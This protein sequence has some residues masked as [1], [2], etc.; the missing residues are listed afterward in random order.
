MAGDSFDAGR[1]SLEMRFRRRA[2]AIPKA[3]Y[4]T[5]AL[6]RKYVAFAWRYCNPCLMPDAAEVLQAFYMTLRRTHSAGDTTPI[7]TR[8]LEALVRLSE[9]R[10]K[11]ELREYVTK[12]DA[13][14][15]VEMMKESLV[16]VATDDMG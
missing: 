16:D 4:L 15:V 12:E 6:L 2:A 7:T 10:A 5:P 9:A 13:L 1:E 3:Q 14:E 11:L 8:Q